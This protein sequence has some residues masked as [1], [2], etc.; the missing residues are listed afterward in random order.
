MALFPYLLVI[1]VFA[2]AKLVAPVKDWL[3]STD[4]KIPWPGLSGE[5]L[6]I[7]GTPS[8]A[9]TYTL[10]WLSS[11]GTMLLICSL[12]VAFVYGIGLATW[13]AEAW[14]HRAQDALRLPH[15]RLDAR[16]GLRHE[17]LGPDDHDRH[18][19]RGAGA[20]VRLPQPDCSGWIG[21]AVTG[22]DTSANALFATLQQSAA[23]TPA[24]T[25]RCSSPPTPP[26][27]SSAR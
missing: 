1:V 25:R 7:A 13:G 23:R 24:S 3:T 14:G 2:I 10:S 15:G 20:P 12:I 17:P 9:T 16:P 22:S 21:T 19:D 4:V 6:T 11:P 18:L 27:E 8:T 5:V 26:A